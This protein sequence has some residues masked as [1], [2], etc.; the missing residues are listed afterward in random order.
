MKTILS[1]KK[2]SLAQKE[3]L[4][5]AKLAVVDFDFIDTKTIAFQT[6]Q[7]T[8]KN[9]IFTSKNGVNAVF[10]KNIEIENCFCVG[11]RTEQLL[12]EK[13]QNV[14]YSASNAEELGKHITTTE[15]STKSYYYF[16]A[17]K[18][19]DTLPNKLTEQ[20][21]KWTETPVYK[22]VWT[23][24]KYT[25]E[26]NGVLFFSPSGV[27]S[28]FSINKTPSHSFCIGNT[29]AK[30]LHKYTQNYTVATKPSVENVLIKAIKH[31]N[32]HD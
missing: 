28:Y 17:E 1:T 10:S 27:E 8:I 13:K 7:Q 24:K 22:T 19:L 15:N 12:K 18:R 32:S 5:N 29:T 11:Q 3:R 31:F 30:A 9:A 25:Q 14:I 16:C 21:I 26:F 2:L 23:P 4:L 6:P 20:N